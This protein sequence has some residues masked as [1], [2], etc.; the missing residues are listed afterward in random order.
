[1]NLSL[2]V[3]A[4]EIRGCENIVKLVLSSGRLLARSV[5]CWQITG[6]LK[7]ILAELDQLAGRQD[8]EAPEIPSPKA[9]KRSTIVCSRASRASLLSSV[10]P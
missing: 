7:A 3:I 5:V 4:D 10:A 6:I 9:S 2:T 1:M 8:I